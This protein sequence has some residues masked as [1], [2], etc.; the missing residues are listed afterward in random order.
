M[1]KRGNQDFIFNKKAQITIFIILGILI[2]VGIVLFYIFSK[3][4]GF[5]STKSEEVDAQRYIDKCARNAVEK[6]IDDIL[7]NGGVINPELKIMYKGE[8]Y[9]YLCYSADYYSSCINIHPLLKKQIE[10]QIKENTE[11]EIKECFN[12]LKSDLQNKGFVISD[13]DLDYK[14]EL[15]PE[16]V[17][18]K[19]NKEF[20]FVKGDESKTF[21]NF[22][23]E[24]DSYIYELTDI[25]R[26]I[27]SQ[28][29]RFCYF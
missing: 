14:I 5:I 7:K 20:N 26:E 8:N 25:T 9:T 24:V 3:N 13:K 4:K 2:V 28:E 21:T 18:I 15:A 11:E 27:V 1:K 12:S 22:D 19:I 29:A 6:S 17:L 16:K 23:T 10:A